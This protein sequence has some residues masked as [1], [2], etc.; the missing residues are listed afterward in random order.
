VSN[1]QLWNSVER[2]DPAFTKNVEQGGRKYFSIS[3]YYLIKKA[4]EVW[5][6]IGKGWGFDIVESFFTDGAPFAWEFSASEEKIVISSMMHTARVKLWYMDDQDMCEVEDF[7]HTPYVYS[8]KYGPITDFEAPKK[9][10]TDALKKC[11][12]LCGFSADVFLGM[13]DDELYR[14]EVKEAVALEK[15]DNK[16]EMEEAQRQ[17]FKQYV[18][19]HASMIRQASS[20]SELEGVFRVVVR[21]LKYRGEN[22]LIKEFE[23]MK[24]QRKTELEAAH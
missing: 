17:E 15:A 9:S 24:N 11:L 7:G 19:T 14:E 1:L 18:E 16:V 21:K 22:E 6:P 5:G 4:T 10:V 20:M 13:F 23:R 8:S 2:T 3:P 12:S